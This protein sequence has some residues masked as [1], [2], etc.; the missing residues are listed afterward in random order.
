MPVAF[1]LWLYELGDSPLGLSGLQRLRCDCPYDGLTALPPADPRQLLLSSE[2]CAVRLQ[3]AG[4]FAGAGAG[5][6]GSP[7]CEELRFLLR[8]EPRPPAGASA[9]FCDLVR[10]AAITL[11]T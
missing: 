11:K 7:V 9:P 5:R 2:V 3:A 10:G 6:G 4:R 8:G 1:V